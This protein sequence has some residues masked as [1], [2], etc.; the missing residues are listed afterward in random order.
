MYN[1]YKNYSTWAA[2]MW[3]NS[4]ESTYKYFTKA[5]EEAM[6]AAQEAENPKNIAAVVLGDHIKE[7]LQ[8]AAPDVDGLYSDL[9]GRALDSIDYYSIAEL[10][11]DK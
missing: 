2:A 4:E 1:G 11:L 10:F 6:E 7:F 5:A 3:L 9:L 8:E